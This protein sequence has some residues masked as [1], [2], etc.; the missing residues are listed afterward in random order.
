M[1]GALTGMALLTMALLTVAAQ[2]LEACDTACEDLTQHIS[3]KQASLVESALILL[4]IWLLLRLC[5]L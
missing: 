3:A 5:L 4:T 2:A 1:I